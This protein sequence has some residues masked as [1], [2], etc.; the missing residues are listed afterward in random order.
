VFAID[1]IPAALA[2][3]RESF[4]IWMANAF[5]L[6][7]LR[8]L[9]MLV[10]YLIE[11]F[12]YLDETIAVVLGIVGAKI[13]IQDFVKITPVASL[14]IIVVAFATGIAVSLVVERREAGS[15]GDRAGG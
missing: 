7:G 2:I 15:P 4:L 13:L 11:R 1:S 6:M 12:R 9:F 8:S 5:A 3:T 10:D 14:A